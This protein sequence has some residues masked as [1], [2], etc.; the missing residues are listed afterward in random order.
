[1]KKLITILVV[2]ISLLSVQQ[3]RSQTIYDIIKAA[4]VKAI[5][6]ADLKI[7][8]QQNKIIWLQNA[9]KTL[10]NTMSKLKLKEIS[11]WVEKQ[12]TLYKEYYDDL[13][14]V[15]TL[16]TYYQRIRDIT[17]KQ[18]KLLDEY[19]KAWYLFQQD[20]HFSKEELEYMA[21]VYA[22]ILEECAKNIDQIFLVVKSLATTMSDAERLRIIN[23]AADQADINYNDLLQFNRQN[24]LLSLQRSK[25]KHET[26]LTKKL[27]GL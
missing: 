1:M 6:A 15:K 14:K 27:Y 18:L 25:D 5:K 13:A 10:E 21:K 2:S 26:E 23:A 9:Q 17:D 22:G 11:D 7:Q 16:I 24:K 3:A 4:V 8:R 12:R 20:A 19:K